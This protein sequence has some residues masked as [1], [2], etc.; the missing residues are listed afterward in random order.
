MHRRPILL[1]GGLALLTLA[2][3]LPSLGNGFVNLDDS[4]YVT[5]NRV[6]KQGLTWEGLAWA[7]TANVA[8]NWHPLTM[9]SHMLD[10]ELF[11]LNAAGHHG[12]S[13]L[14]HLGNVLLLFEIL[15]RMTGAPWR[16]AAAAGLFA[17][18]P[19]RVESVAWVAERK[20]VLSGLFWILALGAYGRY[21]R[22]PSPKRYLP[23]VLA[24]A[25]GL[26]SKPMVVT[27]PF[28]LLLLDVWPLGRLRL[29]EPGRARRLGRLIV[30]KLPLFALSAVGSLVTIRYQTTSLVSLEVLPWS[31]RLANVAVSYATYLGKTVLPRNLAVFYPIPLEIPAWKALGAAALL[32]ALTALAVRKARKAPWFLVGW[33]WFLGTLVPV[34]G[35][36]QVG[37]QAMAD[38]YT[39][40]P[41]IGLSLAIC[42]GLP[43]VFRVGEGRIGEGRRWRPVLAGATV[44]ALLTLTALTW[45]QV[46]R[47]S[48]SVTLFR[49]A[50]AVTQGNYVAHVALAKSLAVKGD[51]TGAAKQ[52]RGALALRPGLREARIGLRETLRRAGQSGEDRDALRKAQP[53]DAKDGR[54]LRPAAQ[55][56]RLEPPERPPGRG[57]P[58]LRRGARSQEGEARRGGVPDRRPRTL[59]PPGDRRPPPGPPLPDVPQPGAPGAGRELARGAP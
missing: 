15:R 37:R 35:I 25:L 49:H 59:E 9:L 8:N 43:A 50:L 12:M 32:L 14:L 24:M 51:W 34:I 6:V 58:A 7:R 21:V 40:I 57:V 31:L 19:L 10:C 22:E 2:A 28:A 4:L 30:E 18:H 20:D 16:S 23:V 46:R 29:D 36:V 3:F 42:W 39:Y 48:N 5:N 53:R 52:Y 13:L 17:V 41:S 38:R 26:M 44:L 1:A 27:L 55:G 47:W 56:L 54:R 11:G 33:L 45:A